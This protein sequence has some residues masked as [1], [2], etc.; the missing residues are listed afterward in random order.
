MRSP[1]RLRF[2]GCAPAS[3]SKE[4]QIVIEESAGEDILRV[5]TQKKSFNRGAW[6]VQRERFRI[7]RAE[8]W[9]TDQA[10]SFKSLISRVLKSMG[11]AQEWREHALIQKWPQIVGPQIAAHA[12]PAR[13]QRGV[14]VIYVSHPTWL[15]ELE[16]F[17][18]QTILS[19]LQKEF[20]EENIRQIRFQIAPYD[21]DLHGFG[22]RGIPG[23]T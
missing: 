2:A 13:L 21:G 10:E 7:D 9:P 3:L 4:R 5:M 6:E 8:P 18:K 20:P 16:R 15:S 12:Q 22:G 14:V 17:H 11:L 1:S 19:R 23:G